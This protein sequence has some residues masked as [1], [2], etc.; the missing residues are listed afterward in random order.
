MKRLK[1]M[2]YIVV[3]AVMLIFGV[4]AHADWVEE[5]YAN[6]CDRLD[7]ET[8]GA[9]LIENGGADGSNAYKVTDGFFAGFTQGTKEEV[10]VTFDLNYGV[11]GG[12]EAGIKGVS[13]T[14]P[15]GEG[16]GPYLKLQDGV[17]Q[18]QTGV[19]SGQT[20]GEIQEDTWYHFIFKGYMS[21]AADKQGMRF[22]LC[23]YEY[24]EEGLTQQFD[25]VLTPIRS[26][27][28]LYR[29]GFGGIQFIGTGLLIDNLKV[30][31]E[32][33]GPSLTVKSEN[34]FYK[35]P[36]RNAQSG[37]DTY[38]HVLYTGTGEPT[39]KQV[40]LSSA[41]KDVDFT[42]EYESSFFVKAYLW[43]SAGGM[44][45]LCEPLI[46]CSILDYELSGQEGTGEGIDILFQP[47]EGIQVVEYVFV[48]AR[49]QGETVKDLYDQYKDSGV[50]IQGQD[51]ISVSQSGVYI[52]KA[53][54]QDGGT[55]YQKIN[56]VI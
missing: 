16:T 56:I 20:L 15:K 26:A 32:F 2:R 1:R 35:T 36:L 13:F 18:Y 9:V 8:V 38:I 27:T 10:T 48:P 11:S 21:D 29:D 54:D 24:G 34:Y 19:A 37:N 43:D 50:D 12:D 49:G 5:L 44:V 52:I 17:L 3:I 40:H 55:V 33:S 23:V 45:P 25:G 7:S 51:R 4:S 53:K 47:S 46:Y 39:L 41:A 14:D 6:D 28:F 22:E 42:V 31:Q 30:T